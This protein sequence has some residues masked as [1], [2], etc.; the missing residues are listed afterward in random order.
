MPD[1]RGCH[2]LSELLGES[3]SRFHR[4]ACA[5]WLVAEWAPPKHHL[6]RVCN[7]KPWTQSTI[8]RQVV[9]RWSRASDAHRAR[10]HRKEDWRIPQSC[11][12]I[13][14][15]AKNLTSRPAAAVR[16]SRPNSRF[17]ISL[18]EA[19]KVLDAMTSLSQ[20]P[21]RRLSNSVSL[22]RSVVF[23]MVAICLARPIAFLRSCCRLESSAVLD[24]H[25]FTAPAERC[26]AIPL[27][28]LIIVFATPSLIVLQ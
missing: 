10:S 5:K 19:S 26:P 6:Q 23:G 17:E 24:L 3:P 8:P 13:R 15:V 14:K 1:P 27:P 18:S 11:Q 22:S 4:S 21:N 20:S 25:R 16:L 9:T 2:H 28:L 12:T 7:E